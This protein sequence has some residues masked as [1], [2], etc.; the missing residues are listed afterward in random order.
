M[1]SQVSGGVDDIELISARIVAIGCVQLKWLPFPITQGLD[2][3][4]LRKLHRMLV[5][6]HPE[7]T[8]AANPLRAV[9]SAGDRLQLAFL[10]ATRPARDLVAAGP[11]W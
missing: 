10:P 7:N 11:T 4:F 8:D 2:L 9:K 6:I 5:V 3:P 1:A